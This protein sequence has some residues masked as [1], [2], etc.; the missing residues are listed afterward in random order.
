MI[1]TV[2]EARKL[3]GEAHKKYTDKQIEEVIN[4]FDFMA[5]MSI[6]CFLIKRKKKLTNNKK[7]VNKEWKT[8]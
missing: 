6:D 1:I 5:D 3:M 2:E 7:E 4:V 8:A